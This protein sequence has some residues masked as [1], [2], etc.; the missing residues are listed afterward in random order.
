[1]VTSLFIGTEHDCYQTGIR[2]AYQNLALVSN[3]HKQNQGV[4]LGGDAFCFGFRHMPPEGVST[5]GQLSGSRL[6]N[7]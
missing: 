4:S 1:M 7:G 3:R 2:A 6:F 5:S